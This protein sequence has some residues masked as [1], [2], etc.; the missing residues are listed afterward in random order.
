MTLPR[1]PRSNFVLFRHLTS[2]ED[3]KDLMQLFNS[4]NG[5]DQDIVLP[6]V[7]IELGVPS[8]NMTK[9]F[10]DRVTGRV[11]AFR[12]KQI[13]QWSIENRMKE[14]PRYKAILIE[15]VV[16]IVTSL[17]I[18]RETGLEIQF[19]QCRVLVAAIKQFKD[20]SGPL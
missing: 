6:L 18:D 8:P 13:L 14:V 20:L 19:E 7:L 10:T 4:Q 17:L 3:P 5:N 1:S 9:L 11:D 16:G 15:H 2:M 12:E